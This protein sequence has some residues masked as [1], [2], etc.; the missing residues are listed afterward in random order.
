MTLPSPPN[1][2]PA[3]ESD[4]R[5]DAMNDQLRRDVASWSAARTGDKF[6]EMAKQI[7]PASRVA[8]TRTRRVVEPAPV[9]VEKKP[10]K[11]SYDGMT[12]RDF[13]AHRL[14]LGAR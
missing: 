11:M 6:D 3:S 8:K 9:P 12:D 4:R 10:F 1:A 13:M 7:P 5:D 2:D 14:K